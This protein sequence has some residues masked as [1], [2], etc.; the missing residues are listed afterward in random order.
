MERVALV[1]NIREGQQEEY[2][3]RH[4]EVW[5]Q[6]LRDME[7]AGFRQM[8]IFIA[9]RPLFL[10]MEVDH[11]AEA[12]RILSDCPESVRWEEQMEPIM[13]NAEGGSYDPANPYPVSLPEV[14]FWRRPD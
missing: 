13:E 5:P 8:N 7:K 6:V 9:G 12:V 10:Y 1:L 4:R 14:F 2:A 3:R 11:Y